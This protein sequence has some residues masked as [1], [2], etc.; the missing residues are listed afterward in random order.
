[1]RDVTLPEALRGIAYQLENDDWAKTKARLDLIVTDVMNGRS[2]PK[3][4]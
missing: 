2:L 4:I 3:K 1:M